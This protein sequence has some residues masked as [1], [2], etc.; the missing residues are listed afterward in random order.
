MSDQETITLKKA[1]DAYL[2][3]LADSGTK[4]TTVKVYERVLELAIT[5][6][7]ADKKL[8][9][10]LLTQVGK[11]YASDLINKHENGRPKAEPTIKQNKRVFRQCLEYA[12]D[13]GWVQ[14]LNIPKSEMQHARSKK[15]SQEPEAP[16]VESSKETSNGK[17]N[18]DGEKAAS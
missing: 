17:E 5:H 2:A 18:T 12:K 4:A 15:T 11:Y 1:V 9:G 10:I 14:N 6:F 8:S 3:H 16:K 13:Q 7:G